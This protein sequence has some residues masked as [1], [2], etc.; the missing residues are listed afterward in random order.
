MRRWE[1]GKRRK[2]ETEKRDGEERRNKEIRIVIPDASSQRPGTR[3]VILRSH[4]N[5][6][7]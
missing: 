4:E 1:R 3:N 6:G 5:T 7:V 2:W